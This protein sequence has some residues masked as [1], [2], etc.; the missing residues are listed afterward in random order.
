MM[1][2]RRTI[3]SGYDRRQ[4]W[5][6]ARCA[7]IPS[8]SPEKPDQAVVTMQPSLMSRE[9]HVSDLF[10]GISSLSSEDG[11]H[12]WSAPVAQPTLARWSEPCGV[13]GVICDFTPQWH[14]ATGQIL[15]IGVTSYYRDGR[16]VGNL[17][18]RETAYSLYDAQRRCWGEA[19][20]LELEGYSFSGAGC[21][22]WVELEE[23]D[24]LLPITLSEPGGRGF[25]V[26]V[27]RCSLEGEKL[28][29][30]QKGEPLRL[31]VERGL[32][33]PSLIQCNGLFW[34]T[35]RNDLGAYLSHSQDGLHYSPILPWTF[36][37]GSALGSYNTQ[38][39]WLRL[40]KKLFLVYTRHGLDNDH[41][42]RHRAPLLLAEVDQERGRLFRE[43]EQIV[44]PNRGA[45]L[46]NFGVSQYDDTH[47]LICVS[48]WMENAGAWNQVVWTAL[49]RRFPQADLEHL[50]ALP[51]RCGLC[52]L[53]GA[54]NSI[55]LVKIS[56]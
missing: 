56:R 5:V 23:G 48:E 40:G 49:Q 19:R 35:L 13:E 26:V 21:V 45:P 33:E 20:F 11:G 9:D 50:A 12:C 37:D 38:Q 54:D 52:E 10:G 53:S 46:G 39:H 24:L 1:L 51:G 7:A 28:I 2:E 41:V 44:V 18:R 43:S 55:F 16:Q 4:C 17:W 31:D 6:H 14:A 36:C 42:V 22:Q 8:E 29:V 47:A 25:S 34:L 32:V 27:V 15:G 3:A 30:K